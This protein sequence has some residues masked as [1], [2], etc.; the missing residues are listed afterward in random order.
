[1]A[2]LDFRWGLLFLFLVGA[3]FPV[4]TLAQASRSEPQV[5]LIAVGDV[6]LSRNVA[7]R[8]KEK[9]DLNFP[10][11]KMTDYLRSADMTFGNLEC[12]ITKGPDVLLDAM[13]FH[14]HPGVEKALK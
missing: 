5:T 8:I 4:P 11:A 3:L 10:F 7:R 12:P 14:A 9:K 1:M 13:K 2:H 6:M